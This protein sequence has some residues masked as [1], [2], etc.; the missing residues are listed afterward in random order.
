[1]IEI[2]KPKIFEKYNLIAGYTTK[3]LDFAKD[4]PNGLDF[5]ITHEKEFEQSRDIF[6][7]ELGFDKE[8]IIFNNQNHTNLIRSVNHNSDQNLVFDGMATKQKNL[9]ICAKSADCS[10]VLFYDYENQIIGCVHS[11]IKGT[12]NEINNNCIQKMVQLGAKVDT[13]LAYICPTI[14]QHNYPTTKSNCELIPHQFKKSEKT[15]DGKK[16]LKNLSYE[17]ESHDE[18]IYFVDIRGMIKQQL[19]DL[20]LTEE[21]IGV[22]EL[23]TYDNA[24][25][26][27]YRREKP[28]NGLG[29]GFIGMID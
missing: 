27:S 28:N 25:L 20:G 14:G 12:I 8:N 2:I 10:V 1:M 21:N 4:M 3:N 22:S 16:L 26:H 6:A 13:I 19:L 11:G 7:S 15:V 23:C 29:I 18:E 9:I 5:K 24:N 17:L